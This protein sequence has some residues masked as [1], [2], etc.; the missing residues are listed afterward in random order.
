MLASKGLLTPLTPDCDYSEEELFFVLNHELI[1]IK[2]HDIYFK[3]L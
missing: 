1:H 2:R 3:L